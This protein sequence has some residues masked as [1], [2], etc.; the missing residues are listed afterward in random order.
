MRP[1]VTRKGH[2]MNET[3]SVSKL[4]L[5]CTVKICRRIEEPQ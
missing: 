4:K 1:V 3:C 2:L 5:M